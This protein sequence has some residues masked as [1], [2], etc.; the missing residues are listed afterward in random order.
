MR[1]QEFHAT[2]RSLK[3]L[4]TL[5]HGVIQRAEHPAGAALKPHAFVRV[6]QRS[7]AIER[8]EHSAVLAI[9]TVPEPER[10]YVIQ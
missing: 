6:E 2:P 3:P 9:Q 5:L 1:P 8:G 10:N 7:I 4:G